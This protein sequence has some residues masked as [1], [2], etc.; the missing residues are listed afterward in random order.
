MP[1][2]NIAAIAAYAKR[3]HT[4]VLA[5]T[6]A[7][8]G[9]HALLDS[10]AILPQQRAFLAIVTPLVCAAVVG[11]CLFLRDAFVKVVRLDTKTLTI[12]IPIVARIIPAI[13]LVISVACG[14]LYLY[15]FDAAMLDAPYSSSASAPQGIVGGPYSEQLIGL[16]IGFFSALEAAF[17][18]FVIKEHLQDALKLSDQQLIVRRDS[19]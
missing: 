16:Y 3:Y 12:R 5:I 2:A 17:T 6:S 7:I 18:I 13:L 14:S 19:V 1:V 4:W 11:Y 8:P 9:L 15:Y 10:E